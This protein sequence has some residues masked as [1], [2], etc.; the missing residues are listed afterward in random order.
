MAGII[1]KNQIRHALITGT[2]IIALSAVSSYAAQTTVTSGDASIVSYEQDYF[3]QYAPVTL[4]DMLQRVPGAQE[5]LNKNRQQRGGPGGGGRR[6]AQNQGERGFGSGGDQILMDG[7]RLAG[8]SNNID[9]TLGRISAENVER[10][11]LIRGAAQG[12]DVQSQGLVINIVLKEGTSNSSTFWQVKSEMKGWN[13]PGLEALV[14]HSGSLDKLDYTLSAARKSNNGFFTRTED[15]FDAA[16]VNT[17]RRLVDTEFHQRGWEFNNNL[18]Y[19]FEDGGVLRLNGLYETEKT[20]N[21]EDRIDTGNGPKNVLWARDR[22]ENQWEVGGDYTKSF[23]GIGNFK[24]LF[25]INKDNTDEFIDRFQD[26]NLADPFLKTIEAE[27]E[28]KKEKIFRASLTRDIFEEQSLEVGGEAA[29]NTFDKSFKSE[30]FD[31]VLDEFV[32]EADDDVK[33]KENRYEIFAH[34]TYNVTDV[35]VVQTSLTTE[36]SKIVAD[37][38][39]PDGTLLDTRDTSFTYFKPRLNLRYDLTQRDQ[40]R[41]TV[42]KKVSQ[43]DFNNFVTNFDQ[44]TE[45]FKI[46]NTQLR[47]EQLWE[48]LLAYEHRLANDSGSFE[49]EGFY[50]DFKDKIE[51]VDFTEYVDL[52]LNPTDRE[53]F[54]GL[55]GM[56]GF[57]AARTYI[58]DEGS[59]FTDKSG[60]VP[61]ASSYGANVKGSLRLGFVGLSDAVLSA[62][63]TY[64]KSSVIN[65]FTLVEQPFDRLSDHRWDINYRHDITDL[66]LSY[67]GRV[68]FNS[69]MLTTDI[70]D[71]WPSSPQASLSVFA[72]YNIFNGIKFRIDAKQLT[73]KRGLST[74]YTY[75]DHIRLDELSVRAEKDTRVLREL[76]VSLQG[77]F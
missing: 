23:D 42:E 57:D 77:T 48:F 59:G 76:E 8:K 32:L 14:S 43:L 73:K 66:G 71:Y 16:D 63:Y 26:A 60:N 62:T 29:I 65:Q 20:K 19:N 5:I 72:E 39:F 28:T 35:F 41:A 18:T 4:L 61:S 25:V 33:I 6:G 15:F 40:L 22:K 67:G 36:F 75:V 24:F 11:E 34:H 52:A 45:E 10:I 74:Q 9:D 54:F 3:A 47:P 51:R 44:R 21:D 37:N 49:I 68:N 17:G 53:T 2:A 55:F 64:E 46:G 70:N 58:I 13:D 31:T 27:L 56:P 30:D 7:K 38:F 69:D 1:R 50:R 12:L